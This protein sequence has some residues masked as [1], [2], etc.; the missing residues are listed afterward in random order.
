MFGTRACLIHNKDQYFALYS[1]LFCVGRPIPL[2]IG[3]NEVE[4]SSVGL[5]AARNKAALEHK[6]TVGP[7]ARKFY[8]T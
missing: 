5:S 2:M 8:L 7:P 4:L 3:K 6:I 1:T